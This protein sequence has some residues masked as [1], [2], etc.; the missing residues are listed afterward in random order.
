MYT[1]YTSG[2]YEHGNGTN[3]NKCGECG[4]EDKKEGKQMDKKVAFT[5]KWVEGA[6]KRFLQKDEILES[7]M[8]KIKYLYIGEGFDNTFV[9]RM[10]ME[11]PPDPFQDMMGGDEWDSACVTGKFLP[12]YIEFAKENRWE[13]TNSDTGERFFELTQYEFWDEHEE[14]HEALEQEI[15]DSLEDGEWEEREAEWDAFEEGVF[16]ERYYKSAKDLGGG[17]EVWEKWY[18]ETERGIQKDI[19]LFTG[20]EVLR[21][22]GAV[23]EN[24]NFAKVMPRLRVLEVVDTKFLSLEGID[25]LVR[26]KQ[27]CCWFN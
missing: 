21:M 13:Y 7:D 10:S 1:A 15:S 26:L 12:M 18:S 20:L 16:C 2:I 8:A 4:K 19:V 23:Y 6:V 11:T 17:D 25:D 3:P 27:F 22:P 9:I 14:E 24:L 5:Q